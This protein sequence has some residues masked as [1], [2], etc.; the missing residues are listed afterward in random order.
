MFKSCACLG[1][2]E[3]KNENALH[4]S[5]SVMFEYLITEQK[6]E[7]FYLGGIGKF[8]EICQIELSKLQLKFKHIKLILVKP[9]ITNFEKQIN[10]KFDEIVN[11]NEKTEFDKMPL[12]SRD[13]LMTKNADFVLFYVSENSKNRAK[14]L[15]DITK[16]SNK[17]FVNMF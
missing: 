17:Q 9:A 5:L 13:Y 1:Q 6:I 2:N 8:D 12:F 14:K 3:I 7:K 16:N 10:F 4:S 11:F 15:L